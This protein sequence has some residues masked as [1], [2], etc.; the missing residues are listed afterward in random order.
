MARS[1]SAFR[2]QVPSPTGKRFGYE[3]RRSPGRWNEFLKRMPAGL[4][5]AEVARRLKMPYDRTHR[6]CRIAGYIQLPR[7]L[8]S[9]PARIKKFPPG[10][11]VGQIATRLRTNYATACELAMIARYRTVR[12]RSAASFRWDDVDWSL[13][14]RIIAKQLGVTWQAASGMRKR[15]R[16]PPAVRVPLISPHVQERIA[17]LNQMPK[18]LQVMEIARR[19]NCGFT[20]PP[21]PPRAS[22]R[23]L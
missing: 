12:E 20:H 18:G 6:I 22:V 17:A 3:F 23:W 10:L 19:L 5:V 15:L 13:S 7:R 14:N 4:K 8:T 2:P 11:T 21:R 16:K 1:V 9:L